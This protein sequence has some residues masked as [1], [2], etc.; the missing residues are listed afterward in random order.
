MQMEW[1]IYPLYVIAGSF[2]ANGVPHYV[3]G[4]SGNAFQSPFA[5]PPAVGESSPVIN[6]IWGVTNFVIG[7]LILFGVGD[8]SFG[9]TIDTAMVGVGVLGAGVGLAIHF[10]R[11]RGAYD[12]E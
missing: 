1:Y 3:N 2:L 9:L 8:F 11:V 6:V 5:S 4:I 12:R 7:F 10:G